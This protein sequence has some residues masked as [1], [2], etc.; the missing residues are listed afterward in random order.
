MIAGNS[1]TLKNLVPS[2]YQQQLSWTRL[3]RL[4]LGKKSTSSLSDSRGLPLRLITMNQNWKSH[5]EIKYKCQGG[6]L[7]VFCKFIVIVLLWLTMTMTFQNLNMFCLKV[8]FL[9]TSNING[10]LKLGICQS[11]NFIVGF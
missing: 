5:S 8:Y 3:F 4:H 10:F 6:V 7:L 9:N 1:T 2:T 11:L